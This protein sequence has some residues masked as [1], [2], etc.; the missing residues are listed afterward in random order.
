L[1]QVVSG[2]GNLGNTSGGGVAFFAHAG[3]F[4]AGAILIKV[5]KTHERYFRSEQYRW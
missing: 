3:G 2:V 1:I 5:M 4:V